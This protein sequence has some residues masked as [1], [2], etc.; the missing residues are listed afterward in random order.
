MPS[1]TS[2]PLSGRSRPPMQFSRVVLPQPDG[3]MI[4]A[5]VPFRIAQLTLCSTRN[6]PPPSC[7][8]KLRFTFCPRMKSA[9]VELIAGEVGPAG[10]LTSDNIPLAH[11]E[12]PGPRRH[13]PV[14]R[15]DH[16]VEQQ[17][18]PGQEEQRG[19]RVFG[20]QLV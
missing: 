15:V 13:Q 12:V 1:T 11:V 7:L 19:K 14:N 6:V 18:E 8:G 10:W 5:T 3:P 2:S 20:A 17:T 16:H 4:A 9:P